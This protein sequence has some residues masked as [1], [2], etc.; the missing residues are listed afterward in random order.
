MLNNNHTDYLSRLSAMLVQEEMSSSPRCFN[1]FS[2]KH[3]SYGNIDESCRK[4]MV[5][6]IQ[7]VQTTLSLSPD[8][9]YIAISIFDQYFSSGKG[10][11]NCVLKEQS[12][13]QLAAIT[14]FYTAIKIHEPIILGLDMLLVLC[15]NAYNEA[16]FISME[17]DI[18]TAIE[19][20]VSYHTVMDVAR[21]LLELIQN[22]GLLSSVDI[23]RLTK[24]CE[25]EMST[26]IADIR[27]SCCKPSKLGIRCVTIALGELSELSATK[28]EVICIRMLEAYNIDISMMEGTSLCTSSY[29]L[30]AFHS[31]NNSYCKSSTLVRNIH[32]T[33]VSPII[34]CRHTAQKA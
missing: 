25:G 22:D 6:W 11:S 28:K 8:T 7:V 14:A 10:N 24:L 12:K 2:K 29:K 32:P 15:R 16:D 33:S 13:F 31:N 30:N 26:A 18:L 27:S 5:T 1:Y 17:V 20:R 23:D 21:T 9:V 4:A 3:H 19:W 34:V